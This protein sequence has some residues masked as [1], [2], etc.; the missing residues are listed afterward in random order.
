MLAEFRKR[1]IHFFSTTLIIF[2]LMVK[3]L[4]P[5]AHAGN[6]SLGDK[7]SFLATLCSGN[8]IVFVDLSFSDK[9]KPAPSKVDANN[10][11][12]LC[13]VAEQDNPI[14]ITAEVTFALQGAIDQLYTAFNHRLSHHLATLYAIRAPPIFS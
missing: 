1:K 12:P 3:M 10:K 7:K 13:F 5:M 11:C 6:T 2:A 8:K 4:V 9:S 14:G